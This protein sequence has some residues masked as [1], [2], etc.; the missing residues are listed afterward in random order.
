MIRGQHDLYNLH[1]FGEIESF[2]HYLNLRLSMFRM[3]RG[4]DNIAFNL[5]VLK[6]SGQ[7]EDMSDGMYYLKFKMDYEKVSSL[8]VDIDNFLRADALS[9]VF[10][11]KIAPEFSEHIIDATVI[12]GDDYHYN[13]QGDIEVMFHAPILTITF[14][15]VI[16]D[17]IIMNKIADLY[18]GLIEF[19]FVIK[20]ATQQDDVSDE[21]SNETEDEADV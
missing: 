17:E 18:A 1:E 11:E 4:Y 3:S 21:Q 13:E 19:G 15:D 10:F 2:K 16:N 5:D 14:K 9:V 8:P 12:T 6:D 7:L 20:P